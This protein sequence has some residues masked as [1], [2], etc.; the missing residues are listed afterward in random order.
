METHFIDSWLFLY[1]RDAR[2]EIVCFL[3]QLDLRCIANYM[4]YCVNQISVSHIIT[5]RLFKI[6]NLLYL[7]CLK[8]DIHKIITNILN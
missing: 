4:G 1:E 3:L 7:V 8:H 5:F 6:K 2:F